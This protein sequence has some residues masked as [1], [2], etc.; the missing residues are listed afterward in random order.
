V[1]TRPTEKW[2]DSTEEPDA[3][4]NATDEALRQFERDLR[5]LDSPSDEEVFGLIQS[6]VEALNDVNGDYN[7]FDE[8]DRAELCD[9]ID[10]SLAEAGIDL[11]GLAERSGVARSTLT[12]EW[13]D[14]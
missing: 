8:Y 1:A 9:F 12:D 11:D 13:R 3:R 4:W 14:W 6:V 5:G 2:L 10:E 7:A